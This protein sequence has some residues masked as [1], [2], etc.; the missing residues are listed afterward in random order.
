M[1]HHH[2]SGFDQAKELEEELEV[3]RDAGRD[4]N[5]A[6]RAGHSKLMRD[7]SRKF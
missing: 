4:D 2:A 7:R 6:G 5:K 3:E 1:D